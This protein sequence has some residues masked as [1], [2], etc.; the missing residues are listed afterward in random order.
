MPVAM[1][2]RTPEQRAAYSG[3]KDTP[4]AAEML[5]TYLQKPT[6]LLKLAATAVSAALVVT[7]G[8]RI[9]AVMPLYLRQGSSLASQALQAVAQS[10]LSVMTS[11]GAQSMGSRLVE[12]VIDWGV[13]AAV[14]LAATAVAAG[15]DDDEEDDEGLD[16]KGGGLLRR[17]LGKGSGSGVAGFV[18]SKEYIRIESLSDKLSSMSYTIEANTVSKAEAA[19][20]QRRSSLSRR[21]TDELGD[22]GEAALAGIAAAEK[23]WRTKAAKP[24]AAA[25]AARAELR[26]ISVE[27]GGACEPKSA[28]SSRGAGSSAG[29]IMGGAAQPDGSDGARSKKEVRK[30][31]REMRRAEDDLSDALSECAALE[32]SFSFEYPCVPL[33]FECS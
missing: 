6:I 4:T 33:P 24:A 19:R 29:A 26:S 9:L 8:W 3:A 10:M 18:P 30:L 32:A 21:F 5:I 11:P 16:G 31:M 12:R 13:P 7:Y 15:G 22:V 28:V 2:V 14:V 27:L 25:Q 1:S 23:E 20:T 17:L